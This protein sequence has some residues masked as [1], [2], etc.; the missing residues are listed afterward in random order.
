VDPKS[1]SAAGRIR[2]IEKSDD[3]IG[4]RTHDFPACSIVP[5]PTTLPR[6]LPIQ[7]VL[8]QKIMSVN[9]T[10][11]RKLISPA[12]V[13]PYTDTESSEAASHIQI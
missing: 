13:Y 2:S 7:W 4:N 6:A 8:K 9:C 3:L 11:P 12:V 5:Q 1:N 10:S